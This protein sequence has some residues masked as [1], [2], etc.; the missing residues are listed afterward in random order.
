MM[1]ILDFAVAVA[2]FMTG[3]TAFGFGG[4]CVALLVALCYGL[5]C[6]LEGAGA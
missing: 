5:A 6:Y 4:A 1:L 2:A 3:Y